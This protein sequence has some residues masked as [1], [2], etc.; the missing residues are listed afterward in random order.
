MF[1]AFMITHLDFNNTNDKYF[2]KISNAITKCLNDKNYVHIF[3][4]SSS[5]LHKYDKFFNH[6]RYELFHIK[7][8]EEIRNDVDL[9]IHC[10]TK[11]VSKTGFDY[12]WIIKIQPDLLIFD[13]N[14]FNHIKTKYNALNVHCRVRYY[15]GPKILIKHERSNWENS[16]TTFPK[17]ILS[18]YD[19]QLYMIPYHLQVFAFQ[20]N[21][22]PIAASSRNITDF[23]KVTSFYD[24][25]ID[26]IQNC[27]E[28]T[29][30][31]MWIAF[32]IPVNIQHFY[33]VLYEDLQ[34]HNIYEL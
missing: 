23:S 14:I 18:I 7:T 33:V 10:Y 28:K 31:L 34:Q 29:Q 27:D 30:T 16:Y 9:D 32:N 11:L 2:H 5:N 12:H 8:N 22:H 21:K 20:K 4:S 1:V 6:G 19:N 15:V 26:D 24:L 13:E 17:E 3:F 25:K